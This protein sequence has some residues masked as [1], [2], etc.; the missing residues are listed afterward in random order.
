MPGRRWSDGLHQ[1]IESKE[2]LPIQ[3]E[4][5]TL[6]SITYQNFFLLYPRLAGMTGTAKTEELEFEKT[7]KLEVTT[8]PTNRISSRVDWTDQVYKTEPAKWRAVANETAEIHGRA[9]PVLVGTTSVEKSEVLSSLLAELAIPHNLLNAKPENVEREAEIIAQAGRAGA[10]TIATNMAGRGTDIILGG[11]SDYMARLKCRG[12]LL[13]VLVRPEDGH[14]APIPYQRS[15]D[16]G[17]GFGAESPTAP[18]QAGRSLGTL[19]PCALS[20]DTERDLSAL[21]KELVQQWGDRS[22]TLLELEDRIALAAEKAPTTDP[23]IQKMRDLLRSIKAEYDLVVK[24]EE[25][26]VREAGGLHVIGTERHESRR[27]DNQLRGRSGRQGDPGTTRFFLSLEDNLLRIFGGDR[28]AGLM[29][30]FRVE[31]D[32]P[33]ESGMLTRSLEGAQKKVETYYYDQR[34]DV[35]EY[36]EVMNNQ[37]KAVY[38]ERRR[39]LEGRELKLQVL[40]YGERTIDDIVEAYVNP[41]LPPEEWDLKRLLDKVKEFIYLL[42]DLTPEQLQGL[43][44]DEL[45]AFLQEQMRNA[46][47]IKEDQVNQIRPG[48]MREAERFFI[49]QQIDTLWREHLQSMEALRETIYLR[50]YGQQQPII[51]YKNE[52]YDMF[53]EMMTQM[54]RNVIYSMF[55]FQ[56]Q[57]PEQV[58]A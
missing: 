20:D 52:A 32:M 43:G 36:D 39:V 48:L 18:P 50:G 25:A 5:Q 24:Q 53:L 17:G 54:R 45:K 21:A 4:T 51:E 31:E 58:T 19:Y 46:Y 26:Q 16:A 10:V 42:E 15:T 56:P 29:N 30:A 55:M 1:A 34:K 28:V 14:G 11:N 57:V 22:L 38:A 7:Y 37:R 41:D 9:R 47:D 33:I 13:P 3:P 44:M 6:A 2:L 23:L 49:L 27:I 40:G 12:V 35:F 8:V